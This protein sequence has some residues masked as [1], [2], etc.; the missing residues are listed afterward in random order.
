[1]KIGRVIII[2]TTT[3]VWKN[4]NGVSLGVIY[5]LMDEIFIFIIFDDIDNT[6]GGEFPVEEIEHFRVVKK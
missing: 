2:N 6:V 1:M 4:N 3:F 5:I